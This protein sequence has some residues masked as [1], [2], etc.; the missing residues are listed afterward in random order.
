M[1]INLH[2]NFRLYSS[3][4]VQ[5]FLR[6]NNR[7][8]SNETT[9]LHSLTVYKCYLPIKWLI[10]KVIVFFSLTCS[11]M[12]GQS[13]GSFSS[14]IVHYTVVVVEIIQF[15]FHCFCMVASNSGN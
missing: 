12:H 4:K 6:L 5:Q 13:N 9:L 3:Y 10:L 8:G 11:L 14:R 1:K 7:F 15:K 2:E